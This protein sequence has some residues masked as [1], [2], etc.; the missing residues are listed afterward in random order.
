VL[1]FGAVFRTQVPLYL[2]GRRVWEA[3]S[4]ELPAPPAAAHFSFVDLGA[5]WAGC[6]HIWQHDIRRGIFAALNSPRSA[7]IAWL[8]TR[9]GRLPNCQVRWGS[10]WACDLAAYDVVFAF[11]SP[12]PM[13]ALWLKARREMRSGVCSSAAVLQ[14]PGSHRIGK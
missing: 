2:S 11:L 1:V 5:A 4:L 10:L 13:P 6:C 8:R 12:V 9:L 14:C 7:L 3:L